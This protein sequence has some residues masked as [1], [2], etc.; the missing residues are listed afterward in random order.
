M[1]VKE[2]ML[3][4]SKAWV[5]EKLS[6]DKDYFEHLK[7]MP[8]PNILWIGSSD[9]LISIR[10]VTNTE[11]GEIIV[12]RNIG[13]Q[14]KTDDLSLMATVEHAIEVSKVQ[15]IIVCGYSNCNG[16][17]EVIQGVE[18]RTY[19]HKWLDELFEIYDT[20]P[21]EFEQLSDVEKE[22][23]LCEMSIKAQILKLSTLDIVQRA[24]ERGSSP[25]LLG[26]YLDEAS[27]II[28]EIFSM[29]A[30]QSLKQVGSV[31]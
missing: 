1:T 31:V 16:V 20:H 10:E 15:H 17:K 21:G 23:R 18:E 29:G 25:E 30:K 22:K 3:L 2:R 8:T 9:N 11:P 28:K 7:R 6:L 24:W 14:V 19:M 4:E 12:H 13:A 27:G 5:A 26:W